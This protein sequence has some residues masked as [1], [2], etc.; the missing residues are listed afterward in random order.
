MIGYCIPILTILFANILVVYLLKNRFGETIPVT[1]FMAVFSVYFSQLLFGAF[2]PGILFICLSAL[3][4]A[5]LFVI[6]RKEI[7]NLVFTYGMIA[8]LFCCLFALLILM[9]SGTGD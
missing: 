1:F 4:G 2:W 9:N 6:K 7:R 8:F 3:A 5:V